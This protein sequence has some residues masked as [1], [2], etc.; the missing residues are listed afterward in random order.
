[1]ARDEMKSL[2]I[3]LVV[4]GILLGPVKSFAQTKSPESTKLSTAPTSR[5]IKEP[6]RVV[7]GLMT[8]NRIAIQRSEWI[9]R[10][11]HLFD[12]T[13]TSARIVEGRLEFTGSLQKPGKQSPQIV[14]STLITT[15]ARSANPWPGAS[16]STARAR[17]PAD[18]NKP[19]AERNEQ[20]Q[21]LYSAE[22]D[23]GLGC[24]L[25][26]LKMIAP[27]QLQPIQ[28]GVVLAHQDNNLGN[29][30]NQ[31]IC[32]IVRGLRAGTKVSEP[33]AKLNQL[34]AQK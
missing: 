9:N 26:Y 1:M 3:A 2:Y 17:K 24:E 23:V 10:G 12:Y 19:E 29:E 32:Q 25:I 14:A 18:P 7:S 28:I 20:T 5:E 33:L 22:T 8:E 15:A 21:S 30:I 11:A 13:L 16:S 4:L 6:L 34:L 27:I 31:A